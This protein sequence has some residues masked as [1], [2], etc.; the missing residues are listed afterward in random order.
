MRGEDLQDLMIAGID[1]LTVDSPA[2]AADH[3]RHDAGQTDD[4]NRRP[5]R[6]WQL[7]QGQL[8]LGAGFNQRTMRAVFEGWFYYAESDKTAARIIADGERV[9]CF[10]PTIN[11][12]MHPDIVGC[13]E[14]GDW[15]PQE[16][17]VAGQIVCKVSW[18]VTYMVTGV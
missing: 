13:S 9:L 12:L 11:G 10:L 8:S 16:D 14:I 5:D 17:D 4:G 1:G 15:V 3:F 18:A 2:D 7:L 6:T